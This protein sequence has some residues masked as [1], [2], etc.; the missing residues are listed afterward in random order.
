MP[1]GVNERGPVTSREGDSELVPMDLIFTKTSFLQPSQDKRQA[2]AQISALISDTIQEA[3]S[4]E[5]SL[6]KLIRASS[7]Y[8]LTL[9][10]AERWEGFVENA[11]WVDTCLSSFWSFLS[12]SDSKNIIESGLGKEEWSTSQPKTSLIGRIRHFR[13]RVQTLW[14]F[15]YHWC[16]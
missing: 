9:S 15:F 3:M 2:D 11:L 8:N 1:S 14:V 10:W 6:G 16:S 4:L 13:K 7:G 5:K 12:P